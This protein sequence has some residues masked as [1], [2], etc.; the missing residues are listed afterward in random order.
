MAKEERSIETVEQIMWEVC[1]IKKK[2]KTKKNKKLVEAD[3]DLFADD[4][5]EQQK[6]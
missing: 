1:G 2:K 5:K 4:E 6:I 3:I